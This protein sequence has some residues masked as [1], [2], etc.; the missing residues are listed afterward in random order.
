MPQDAESESLGHRR[1]WTTYLTGVIEQG[2]GNLHAALVA[3]QDPSLALP[4]LPT[5]RAFD[6][7]ND[8]CLL[9]ALNTLLIIRSPS[10][11]QH[12]LAESIMAA[13]EPLI[14][15][16]PHQH[17]NKAIVSSIFLLKSIL[18]NLL[19]NKKQYLQTALNNARS[20]NNAQLL[21]VAM[22]ALTSMFFKD[23]VGSQTD[24]SSATAMVLSKRAESNLWRAVANGLMANT[25]EMQGKAREAEH[26]RSEGERLVESLPEGVKNS[27]LNE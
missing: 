11:P 14:L 10:H 22:N 16:H 19:T 3:F 9:A 8:L 6:S 1:R 27:L 21:A 20:L 13:L 4:T 2:S 12:Y 17:P 25:L 24:K 23:I 15:P 5:T 26:S 18:G 7:Q